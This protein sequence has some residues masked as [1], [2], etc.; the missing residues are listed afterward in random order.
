M[1]IGNIKIEKVQETK[2]NKRSFRGVSLLKV[3]N[4]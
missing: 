2:T 4:Y 1:Q 3:N